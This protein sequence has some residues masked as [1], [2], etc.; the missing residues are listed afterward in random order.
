MLQDRRHQGLIGYMISS[1]IFIIIGIGFLLYYLMNFGANQLYSQ[2][3]ILNQGS[4]HG[5]V[6]VQ[7]IYIYPKSVSLKERGTE[8]YLIG[9]AD[10]K[11]TIGYI[12]LEAKKNDSIIKHLY[13]DND[14]LI[15]APYRLEAEILQITD[16]FKGKDYSKK[17]SQIIKLDSTLG[18]EMDKVRFVS[19]SLAKKN[20]NR[21]YLVTVLFWGIGLVLAGTAYL[22][23][24]KNSRALDDLFDIYPE[25]DESLE[26]TI[27]YAHFSLDNADIL[28]YNNHLLTYGRDIRLIDLDT[29]TH[30]N[31]VHKKVKIKGRVS[32]IDMPILRV[33]FDQDKPQNIRLKNIV[34]LDLTDLVIYLNRYFSHIQ[35]DEVLSPETDE[36]NNDLEAIAVSDSVQD[37]EDQEGEETVPAIDLEEL[38]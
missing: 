31:Q 35:T 30:F 24:L 3:N 37:D 6:A 10:K 16:Y 4:Q 25:L 38:E 32:Y 14:S 27:S 11:N 1:G 29:V 36:I 18:E 23:R 13:E 17:A 34:P 8:L 5:N 33:Q 15:D 21:F 28:V 7:V 26:Q 19:L 12:G 20:R 22:K 9:Y 2:N